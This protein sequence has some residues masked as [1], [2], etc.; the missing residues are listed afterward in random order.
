MLVAFIEFEIS[1]AFALSS[2]YDLL[3]WEKNT[4]AQPES[5]F[6]FF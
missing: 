1:N 4:Q 5:Y 2:Q 6:F 3:K